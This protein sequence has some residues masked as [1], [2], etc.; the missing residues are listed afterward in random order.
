[1][2]SMGMYEFHQYVNAESILQELQEL[3]E[4]EIQRLYDDVH[5]TRTQYDR[6]QGIWYSESVNVAEYAIWL[7]ETK[8]RHKQHRLHYEERAISF[9]RAL[10]KL[11][12]DEQALFR[13]FYQGVNPTGEKIAYKLKRLLESEV[14]H[15]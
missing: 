12:E 8:E 7:V 6:D 15:G 2:S 11:T 9:Q 10:S 1:M 13:G 14:G 3:Q 4:L 5:P